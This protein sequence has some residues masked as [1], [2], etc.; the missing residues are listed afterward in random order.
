[1]RCLAA[2]LLGLLVTGLPAAQTSSS[3]KLEEHVFNAGGHPEAGTV[4]SSASYRVTIDAVGECVVGTGLGSA[5]YSMDSGFV[6]AYPPPGEVLNLRF[7]NDT[8][9][10]WD[11]EPSVGVYNLYRDLLGGL[12]GLGYGDC[13]QQDLGDETATDS[14]DP[15]AADGYFYL[16]TA[17]NRLAEEGTKGWDS[18]NDERPNPDPCP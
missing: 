14:E 7:A 4:L 5:S 11:P 18:S 6:P 3:Y 13:V 15:P 1:M 2:A 9:L 16:V 8:T 17:E 10:Q 12:S